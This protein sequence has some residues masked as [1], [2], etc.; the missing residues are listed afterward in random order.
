MELESSLPCHAKLILGVTR[1]SVACLYS[2][3]LLGPL[4]AEVR[5]PNL[6]KC[7]LDAE[8]RIDS[9]TIVCALR[10]VDIVWPLIVDHSF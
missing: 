3:P 1:I 5:H 6:A 8:M 9:T 7:E 4:F 10:V 2:V